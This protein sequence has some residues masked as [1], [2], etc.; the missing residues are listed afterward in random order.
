L[1]AFFLSFRQLRREEKAD[2]RLAMNDRQSELKEVLKE[3]K[4]VNCEPWLMH[5]MVKMLKKTPFPAEKKNIEAD[6]AGN[7]NNIHVVS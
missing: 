5:K 7:R 2:R 3:K 1:G 4:S 6:P